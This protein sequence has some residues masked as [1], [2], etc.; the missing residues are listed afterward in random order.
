MRN[1]LSNIS[2]IVRNVIVRRGNKLI[3]GIEA[4]RSL[5]ADLS[6]A[7]SYYASRLSIE[8]SD[9]L[10]HMPMDLRGMKPRVHVARCFVAVKQRQWGHNLTCR[11]DVA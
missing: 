1:L 7:L 5:C 4:L 11:H 6:V 8:M 2:S 9:V 3:V 10:W